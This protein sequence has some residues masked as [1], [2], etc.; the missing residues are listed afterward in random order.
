MIEDNTFRS[1]MQHAGSVHRH[2]EVRMGDNLPSHCNTNVFSCVTPNDQSDPLSGATASSSPA[3][4]STCACTSLAQCQLQ[5]SH[6]TLQKADM[7]LKML[8]Y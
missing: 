5:P 6:F 1:A 7:T 3:D 2:S 8:S 4:S